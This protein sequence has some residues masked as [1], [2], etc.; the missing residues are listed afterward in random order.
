MNRT[1]VRRYGAYVLT[2]TV[3]VLAVSF[4]SGNLI[5]SASERQTI[6]TLTETALIFKKVLVSAE[7][8]EADTDSWVES[9][10]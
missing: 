5:K 4:Y 1:L 10:L 2:I 7:I 8:E 9:E 6:D 3:T